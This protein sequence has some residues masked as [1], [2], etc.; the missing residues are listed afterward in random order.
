MSYR[1]FQLEPYF[2]EREIENLKV[3][4]KTGW[5]TEGPFSKE[6]IKKIKDYT[7]AEFAVLAN[8]GTLALYLSLLAAGVKRDDEVIVT[9]FS[10][11]AS[12]LRKG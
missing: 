2:N 8:N 1:I 6:F 4:I 10:F 5:V 3:A 9:D 11:N 12:A 7:G